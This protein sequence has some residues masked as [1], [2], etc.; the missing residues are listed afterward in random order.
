MPHGFGE[1]TDLP[2][3]L[4]IFLIG[5]GLTVALSFAVIGF[6]LKGSPMGSSYGRYNLFR[7]RWL[8]SAASSPFIWWPVKLFSVFLLG[9]AIAAGLAGDQ[10]SSS[11]FAPTFVWI[12]WWVGLAFFAA[13]I[14]NLWVL[15]NPWKALFELA[16]ALIRLWRPGRNLGLNLAYPKNWGIWPALDPVSW[17]PLDSGRLCPVGGAQSRRRYGR[18]LHGNYPDGHGGFRQTPVAASTERRSRWCSASWPSLRPRKCG[19][20]IRDL[21]RVCPGKC[22]DQEGQ[23]INCY[24]CFEKSPSRELNI[25]HFAM[26]LSNPEHVTADKLALVVLLL[27]SVTFDGFSATPGW[28]DFQSA[29]VNTFSGTVDLP[30]FDSLTLADTLGVLLFPVVFF[31]AFLAFCHFMSGPW[32]EISKRWSWPGPSPTRWRPSR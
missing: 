27:A 17:F 18:F 1:R 8:E 28:V 13:L 9:L 29:M 22:L 19:S 12:I 2:V 4:G 5:A 32:A 15:V 24:Q 14:G 3:P 30:G 10:T 20:G 25:R 21:C 7:H 6:F 31:L 23:C 11:N 26:G 16:E